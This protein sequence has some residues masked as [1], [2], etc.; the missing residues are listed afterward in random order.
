MS[1][2]Q[3]R[4]RAV[5]VAVV[6]FLAPA[7]AYAAYQHVTGNLHEVES[8]VFFRSAQLDGPNLTRLILDMNIRTIINLRG[9]HP[10]ENWYAAEASIAEGYGVHY[11]PIPLSSGKE[12]DI[13]TMLKIAEILRSAPGPILVH[14]RS[15]ADRT[16]LVSAI[17]ELVV[18]GVGPDAAAAQLSPFYGHFPWFGSRTASMDHAFARFAEYW[19]ASARNAVASG[20]KALTAV[21]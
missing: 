20:T 13:A 3:F 5:L 21:R 11:I 14:C 10:S 17:Y 12:P 7:L 2:F 9:A 4:L 16:S 18:E 1:L 6:A 15:G 8:G 19:D